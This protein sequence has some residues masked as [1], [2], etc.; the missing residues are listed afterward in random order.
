MLVYSQILDRVE[1][2]NKYNDVYNDK[3]A[4]PLIE[5]FYKEQLQSVSYDVRIG[6]KIRVFR[7]EFKIIYLDQKE[8][9]DSLFE[10]KDIKGGY[11]LKPNEFILARLEERLNM[12][13]DLV[14]NIRARTT[15][16]KLGLIITDQHV[17]PSYVGNLQIGIKNESPNVVVLTPELIIGQI[18]FEKLEQ[19]IEEDILYANKKDSKYNFENDFVGSKIYD[20]ETIKKA[21]AIYDKVLEQQD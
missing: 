11:K 1:N 2:Y 21:K 16:N 17:N 12:P 8:D 15:F 20:E 7:D 13:N 14:A 4:K 6:N 3:S 10:E 9:I 19:K 5:N 18:V